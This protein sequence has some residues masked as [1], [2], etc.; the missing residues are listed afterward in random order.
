M[1]IP[2]D[3]IPLMV[4]S[5]LMSIATRLA[6]LRAIS[7]LSQEELGRLAGLSPAYV[8]HIER[9][10]GR[11]IAQNLAALAR[12]LGCSLDWLVNEYGQ[13]PTAD[14]VQGSVVVARRGRYG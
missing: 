10:E 3:T 14:H 4:Y 7:G 13:P 1:S 12:V 2:I 6:Q 5:R 11:P 9:G 8:G